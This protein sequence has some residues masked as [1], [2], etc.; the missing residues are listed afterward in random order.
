M[1]SSL[2]TDTPCLH[3]SMLTSAAVCEHLPPASCCTGEEG[4]IFGFWFSPGFCLSSA[5][6]SP[7]GPG[8]QSLPITIQFLL[9]FHL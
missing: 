9:K 1:F 6:E 4:D 2:G 8:G 3:L 5:L 7:P